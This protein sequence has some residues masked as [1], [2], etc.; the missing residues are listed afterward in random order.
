MYLRERNKFKK[1]ENEMLFLVLFILYYIE[2]YLRFNVKN[3]NPNHNS[4][5]T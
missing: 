2:I 4:S 5:L 1:F 3:I